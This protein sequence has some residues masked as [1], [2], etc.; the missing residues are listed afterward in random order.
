MT[1]LAFNSYGQ[2]KWNWQPEF[3]YWTKELVSIHTNA[4]KFMSL[5]RH[6]SITTS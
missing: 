1:H 2:K 4:L 6:E 3:K 5:E